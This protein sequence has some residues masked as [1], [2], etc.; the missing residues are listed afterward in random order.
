MYRKCATEIS[1][2]HQRQVESALLELM[3][4]LSFED[5]TVTQLCQAAG[6]SRRIFYHL[7]NNKTGALHAMI[8]HLILD[9]ESYGMDIP[10]PSVRF[11]CYWKEHRD[12]LDA[13]RNNQMSGLLLERMIACVLNEAYELRYLLKANGW[14]KEEDVILFYL[15]GT[16]GLIFRWYYS[17]FRESPQEM[18]ELLEKIMTRPFARGQ[19]A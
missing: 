9:S 16:M 4:K 13:L 14:E 7:F 3:Q 2:Q 5:I 1:V 6:I 11:F 8:D 12:L 10:D 15:S 18:G 19:P 17:G